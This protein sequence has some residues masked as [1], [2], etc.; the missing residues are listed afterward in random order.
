MGTRKGL[1]EYKMS[2]GHF[3]SVILDQQKKLNNK[4]RRYF[5]DIAPPQQLR[6]GAVQKRKR[7][8]R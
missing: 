4:N 3:S 5:I 1:S 2:T 8:I 7:K 6:E